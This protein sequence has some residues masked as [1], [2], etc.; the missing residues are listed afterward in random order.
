MASYPKLAIVPGPAIGQWQVPPTPGAAHLKVK[1]RSLFDGSLSTFDE[2]VPFTISYL[3]TFSDS[4]VP[5][6]TARE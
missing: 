2:D 4:G 6:I 1:V 3:I 5:T